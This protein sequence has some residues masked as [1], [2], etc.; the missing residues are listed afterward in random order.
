MRVR[1]SGERLVVESVFCYCVKRVLQWI[2]KGNKCAYA[3]LKIESPNIVF[4]LE[5][6]WKHRMSYTPSVNM[7]DMDMMF[8]GV[9]SL[10]MTLS[11]QATVPRTEYVDVLLAPVSCMLHGCGLWT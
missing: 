5:F 4:A 6:R 8:A 10:C 11:M 7:R 2:P 1:G 3:F 9:L